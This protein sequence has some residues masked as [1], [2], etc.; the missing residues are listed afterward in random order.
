[1]KPART[2]K[3]PAD[4]PQ[5]LWSLVTMIGVIVGAAMGSGRA[6]WVSVL[7]MV[8][9]TTLGNFVVNIAWQL[10]EPKWRG[11]RNLDGVM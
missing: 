4:E 11:R 7:C 2:L 8:L 9:L 6:W 10:L 3:E 1:M 5:W